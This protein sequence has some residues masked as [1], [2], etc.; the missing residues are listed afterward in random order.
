MAHFTLKD[1]MKLGVA[2]AATQIEG[3]DRNNSWYDWWRKGKIKDGACPERANDHYNRFREDTALLAGA[4][5]RNYRFGV[6]WSR[7]EP[8]KGVFSEEALAHYREELLLLKEQKIESLLTLHHFTNPMW[9]EE[10]GAFENPDAVFYFLRFVEKVVRSLGDLVNEYITINEPNVYAFLSYFSGSWPPGKQSFSSVLRV[11]RTLT[12]CHI[13][14]YGLI[15]RLREEA[16]FHDTKVS[17]A[18]HVRV[19]EP[20]N[21]K[22]PWHRICSALMEYLFQDMVAKA[23]FTGRFPFPAGR[24]KG[25]RAGQYYDFIG[26]NYYTRSTV[27]G[28]R[29]GVKVNAPV[30]DLGWEIYPEGIITGSTKFYDQYRAP[31]YITENGTCDNMDAFRCRYLFDHLKALSDSSLPVERYYH[32]CF[33]DNFE[34]L[35]GE[36]ARFGLVHVNF[37]TQ[38][39]IMK[40]SGEFYSAMIRENGV[41][42]ELF[43]EYAD[44]EY[45]VFKKQWWKNSVVYQIYPR[46]FQD[47]NGDGIGDLPGIRSR[48]LYLKSLGIDVIWLCPVYCS[49]NDDNGYDI[50]DYYNIN[51]EYGTMADMDLLI[52]D[53][54]KL[55][56][57]ILMDL[58]INHTSDEHEWFMKSRDQNSPYHDYYF[59]KEGK[60]GKPYSNWTSFFGEKAWQHDEISGRQYLHLFSKKQ[61]DL[62]YRNPAVLEEIKKIMRFWLD[63]G[64][65]GFRCDVINVIWKDTL[66]NGRKRLILTGIEHYLSRDGAHRILQELRRDVLS[67]YDCFTVGETVF[68]TPSMARDL[69]DPSRSELDMVFPF[70]HME[71]DQILVKWLKKK[72]D[73]PK[74]FRTIA[75]WQTGVDWAALYLENHDQPRSISRFGD[76]SAYPVESAKLL[77]L[78]LLTLRG[79]PFI[80]QGQELG[81]TNF[82]IDSIDDV[83]DVE[84]H[85]I[86]RLCSKLGASDKLC[87]KIIRKTSRDNAR[88]PMQW[89][90]THCG[91]FTTGIP[92]LKV[93]D[94]HREINVDKE[95]HDDESVLSFYKKMI[96]FRKNSKILLE[97]GFRAVCTK[98]NCFVYR[99][100]LPDETVT[101]LLNFS[102][103]PVVY[104]FC[105]EVLFSCSGKT[106]YDGT[107]APYAGFIIKG[108]A[109]V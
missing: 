50:S 13:K 9:F 99:R 46:S 33:C 98:K 103:K 18:L 56:I 60:N 71:C 95:E 55:G 52:R 96:E 88:T 44:Q 69:S 57:R 92:W 101:V 25:I 21:P 84:S 6:E 24:V 81:M 61:P 28:F 70:E 100:F 43:R 107:L 77:C 89:E 66:E 30:N 78:F 20:E 59:W 29:D 15:H 93:N 7:I 2:T 5:I 108:G 41:S 38:E 23:A 27:S 39:R 3:G 97:G 63:K 48:L 54:A 1:G 45:P 72:L 87:W 16:G 11:Y 19:F 47:S 64:I 37:E 79:T 82:D 49:P 42:E 68:V 83:R 53:A 90:L 26:I 67:R 62:N 65:A 74:F 4:G 85:N 58:V 34:W 102:N 51:P 22:N 8:E 35:E 32:W 105:G 14:A 86:F 10:A 80:Y 36:S 31:L 17:F 104:P 91:G 75:K 12:A 106:S 76:P 94:N 73:R 40:R 109:S